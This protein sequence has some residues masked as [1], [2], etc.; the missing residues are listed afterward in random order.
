MKKKKN[1]TI[2]ELA[3]MVQRGFEE[4]AT[5]ADLLR[6]ENRLDQKIDGV[7][8]RLDQKIDGVEQRLELK[9]DGIRNIIVVDQG[10]RIEKLEKGLAQT[11]VALGMAK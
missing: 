1:M 2:D 4:T 8:K 3:I 9:I 7:E 6:L 11:K 5:K 10:H